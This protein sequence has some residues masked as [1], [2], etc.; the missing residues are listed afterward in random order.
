MRNSSSFLVSFV[1][2]FWSKTSIVMGHGSCRSHL[3]SH[4]QSLPD[5]QSPLLLFF[6]LLAII[7]YVQL[8]QLLRMRVSS[9]TL[10]SRRFRG[11]SAANV[12]NFT[13][14]WSG[15]CVVPILFS[16]ILRSGCRHTLHTGNF[17]LFPMIVP[18]SSSNACVASSGMTRHIQQMSSSLVLSLFILLPQ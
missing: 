13:C 4:I 17:V 12:A 6:C 1:W 8:N 2:C 9:T 18:T 11:D 14:T 10:Q 3:N 7:L 15:L 5:A 16:G